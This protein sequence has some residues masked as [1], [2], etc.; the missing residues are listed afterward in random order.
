MTKGKTMENDVKAIVDDIIEGKPINR[1]LEGSHGREIAKRLYDDGFKERQTYSE[2]SVASYEANLER[3]NDGLKV[4]ITVA[5]FM[6]T[7]TE[8]RAFR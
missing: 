8:I 3:A 4:D 2:C 6:G 5:C 7:F 1:Q